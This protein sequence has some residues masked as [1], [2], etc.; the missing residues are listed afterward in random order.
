[1]DDVRDEIVELEARIE[2]LAESIERCRKLSFAAKLLIAAGAAWIALVLLGLIPF[3]PYMVIAAMA[4]AIGGI[5]LLGSNST[6]WTQAATALQN[7]EATR[8]E[9]IGRM[10]MRVVEER[11]TLH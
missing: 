9:L 8:A 11:P 5:V 1:M 3:V 6:T 7:A 10:E 4:A 2:G